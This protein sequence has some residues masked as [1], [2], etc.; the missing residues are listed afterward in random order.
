MSLLVFEC[1][2]HQQRENLVEQRPCT[3]LSRLVRQ[4]A[5]RA[6]AL[7]RCAVLDLQEHLHDLALLLLLCA[8][9]LLLRLLKQRRKVLIVLRLHIRQALEALRHRDVERLP[10]VLLWQHVI[11]RHARG[12][13]GEQLAR[14]GADRDVACRWVQDDVAIHREHAVQLLV[15]QRAVAFL[16]LALPTHRIVLLRRHRAARSGDSAC[17]QARGDGGGGGRL[18]ARLRHGGHAR[19]EGRSGTTHHG[20]GSAQTGRGAAHGGRRLVPARAVA[21]GGGGGHAGRGGIPAVRAGSYAA[22]SGSR[23]SI[24][25]PARSGGLVPAIAPRRRAHPVEPPRGGVSEPAWRGISESARCGT[26]V[27]PPR[28]GVA[29]PARSGVSKPARSGAAVEAARSGVPVEPARRG[30]SES[31]GGGGGVPPRNLGRVLRHLPLGH[32]SLL[33]L[34][35]RRRCGASALV[36]AV[37]TLRPRLRSLGSLGRRNHSWWRGQVRP[38]L[39]A[40]WLCIQ[41]CH[42]GFLFLL[43]RHVAHGLFFLTVMLLFTHDVCVCTHCC[44][45]SLV[46]HSYSVV[47]RR[48]D[49]SIQS[50]FA[51]VILTINNALRLQKTHILVRGLTARDLIQDCLW[52]SV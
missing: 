47:T 3:K 22:S 36:P 12:G 8:Q 35:R 9:L 11:G 13:R 29:E 28:S 51:V 14:G 19:G 1:G 6:L 39:G 25:Q 10:A 46:T 15:R 20:R 7:G 41:R 23:P 4:L 48:R 30:I 49:E 24:I 45:R 32:F 26:A 21:L 2:G 52:G 18:H 40:R 16:D 27:E 50:P 43:L 31:P 17:T 34:I 37:A 33:R 38:H 5:Q 44:I 42:A